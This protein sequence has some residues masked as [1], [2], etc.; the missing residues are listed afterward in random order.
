[1][2][3]HNIVEDRA[4]VTMTEE[5]F[6]ILSNNALNELCNAIELPEFSTRM[7]ADRFQVENLLREIHSLLGE[8]ERKKKTSQ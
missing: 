7:G 4:I 3:V 1:M 8:L 2:Q 6:L 5:E